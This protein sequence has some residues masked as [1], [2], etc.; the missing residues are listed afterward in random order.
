M[1]RAATV[2]ERSELKRDG[3]P[4]RNIS[5]GWRARP[6]LA[7]IGGRV[8]EI[9][10]AFVTQY[11]GNSIQSGTSCFVYLWNSG[12]PVRRTSRSMSR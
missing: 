11:R 3:R 5:A 9:L 4:I 2:R 1:I 6:A 12:L 7:H 8:Y 10:E